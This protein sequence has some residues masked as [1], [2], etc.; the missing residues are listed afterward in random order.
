M[1]GRFPS[2]LLPCQSAILSLDWGEEGAVGPCHREREVDC[3]ERNILGRKQRDSLM[4]WVDFD[5]TDR[6]SGKVDTVL[7]V[8]VIAQPSQTIPAHDGRRH[9]LP[10]NKNCLI[11]HRYTH[12]QRG[13]E[14]VIPRGDHID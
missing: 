5:V 2:N 14:N 4:T 6:G 11:T 8:I 3:R 7:L 13:K 12:L 9:K 10:Q 1:R